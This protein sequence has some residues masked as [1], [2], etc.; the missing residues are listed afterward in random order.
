VTDVSGEGIFFSTVGLYNAQDSLLAKAIATEEDGTFTIDKIKDGTYYMIT[1]MLGYKEYKIDNITIPG[2]AQND[3]QIILEEDS[4]I[5]DGVEI[6]ARVPLLEQRSDRL[7]VNVANNT[8]SMNN[9]LLDVMKQVPGM[10]VSGDKIRMAGQSNMT[11]LINGKTTRYMD[12]ET[13]L[14][15]MPGDNIQKVEVIHQPGAEFEA[16]GTGPIIN[17]ILKKNSLYGTNGSVSVGLGKG[18]DWKYRTGLNMSHYAGNVNVQG[19]IGWR[20]NPYY[21][22][23]D[24]QRYVQGDFYDQVSSDPNFSQTFRS[25]LGVD[26]DISKKHRIGFSSQYKYNNRDNLVS[27]VT[28]IDFE[29]ESIEDLSFESVTDQDQ[30]WF[31]ASI[32][33]YYTFEIDTNGQKLEVDFNYATFQRTGLNTLSN[34]TEIFPGQEFVEDGKTFITSAKVDYIYPHNKHFTFST[35]AQ[36]N[37][38]E[39]DNNFEAYDE[40]EGGNFLLNTFQ[41]NQFIFSEEIIAGYIKSSWSYKKW[42]GTAGLRYEDSKSIGRSV[43]VDTLLTRDIEQF[44]PSL[45]ISREIKGPLA[46]SIAYSYRIDRPRYSSLNP[47][48]FYLDPFTFNRGNPSLQPALTH[49]GKFNLSYEGQPFFNVEYKYTKDAMVEVLEQND[50]TGTTNQV[51]LNLESFKSFNTSLFFPLDFIPKISGYG[52]GIL[53]YSMFDSEINDYDILRDRWTLTTFLSTNFTLPYE[54]NTEIT[55]W[56]NSGELDGV[57]T[58]SYLYGV[59]IGFSKKVLKNKGRISFGVDNLFFR[60]FYGMVEYDNVDLDVISTW[61]GPVANLQFSYKFGNQSLKKKE[62]AGGSANDML[63]RAEN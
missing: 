48:R 11:I 10:I 5:L 40:D 24:I 13:L 53:N 27:N 32:N 51:T 16:S 15:D 34:S 61:D 56:Y 49:S 18:R 36:Y 22:Q 37:L 29:N 17:I 1:S 21:D 39:L 55:G 58:G 3:F 43:Q 9:S 28:S 54:I 50:V 6:K 46:A 4:E 20:D 30:N 47:F 62:N 45:S 23:L 60:P 41:S 52:G 14:R 35:G 19:G 33:P 63:R 25:N 59:D 2:Y 31:L 7:V 8:T 57:I 42:K 12:M 26:W 44:F 38:A